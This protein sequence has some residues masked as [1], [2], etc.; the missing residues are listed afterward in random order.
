MLSARAGQLVLPRFLTAVKL[1]LE[2][3]LPA[4]AVVMVSRTGKISV[5][6]S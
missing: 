2:S 4:A 6:F 3:M 5:V 1:L